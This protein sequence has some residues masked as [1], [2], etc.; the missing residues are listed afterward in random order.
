MIVYEYLLRS[1]VG[2]HNV[3]CNL[4]SIDHGANDFVRIEAERVTKFAEVFCTM[5]WEIAK[6]KCAILS[7]LSS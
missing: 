2:W 3:G 6:E 7:K 5:D 1:F 4:R